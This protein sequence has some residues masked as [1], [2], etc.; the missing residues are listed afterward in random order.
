MKPSMY[1]P[2]G[3]FCGACGA[4]DCNGCLSDDVDQY[5]AG[6]K[7]RTC[8]KERGI[9]FCCHCPDYPCAELHTFMHDEWPHHWTMEPN[10][11][12]IKEHGRDKWLQTQRQEWSCS[13][14][15]V[16]INWYQKTCECGQILEAW[17]VPE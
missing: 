8:S 3:L 16:E 9:D 10:L 7:F 6:C 12:F 15:G 5:V 2:C 4:T 14:C 11:R 13:R 17:D 1:G